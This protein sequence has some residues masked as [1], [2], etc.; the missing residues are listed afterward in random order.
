MRGHN[1]SHGGHGH[2]HGHG[3]GKHKSGI[4]KAAKMN[5]N[6]RLSMLGELAAT[7]P[8]VQVYAL[9]VTD[10][11]NEII[12]WTQDRSDEPNS[13]MYVY[14][15]SGVTL[16]LG[17]IIAINSAWVHGVVNLQFQKPEDDHEEAHEDYARF[18]DSDDLTNT[19][20]PALELSHP[21]RSSVTADNGT[22]LPA[23]KAASP[24]KKT[25]VV[26]HKEDTED[27]VVSHNHSSHLTI[28]QR[29]AIAC[30]VIN[31]CTERGTAVI[32][33]VYV[34][35][36]LANAE[37]TLPIKIATVGFATLFGGITIPGD[38]NTCTEAMKN[39]NE[40]QHTAKPSI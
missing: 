37:I 10:L 7:I 23:T 16:L 12:K 4:K 9:V 2:S 36:A 33:G 13:D 19:H 28:Q 27:S 26:E 22:A 25:A 31:H 17:L 34:T 29:L 11:I 40:T 18:D 5:W 21:S 38:L 39:H 3:G 14:I 1:H 30:D 35:M 32:G 20:K 24:V 15:T 8:N 6:T